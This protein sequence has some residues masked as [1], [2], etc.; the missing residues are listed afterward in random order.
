MIEHG[1][2]DSSQYR[3]RQSVTDDFSSV[4][5]SQNCIPVASSESPHSK[6]ENNTTKTNSFLEDSKSEKTISEPGIDLNG[7]I[8]HL[9]PPSHTSPESIESDWETL[10]P[11]ILEECITGED[12]EVWNLGPGQSDTLIKDT[13]TSGSVPITVQPQSK[14]GQAAFVPG[15]ISGLEEDK[16]GMPLAIFTKVSITVND[17]AQRWSVWMCFCRQLIVLRNDLPELS[18]CFRS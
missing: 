1:L 5:T 10:D 2:T 4:L 11:S 14:T 9:K 16:Y 8:E 12:G 7:S 15:L 17:D 3:P 13:V 18:V 6:D